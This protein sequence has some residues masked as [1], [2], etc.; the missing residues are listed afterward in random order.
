M[1]HSGDIS[2]LVIRPAL[3]YVI[4]FIRQGRVRDSQFRYPAH[5]RQLLSRPRLL[6]SDLRRIRKAV[7]GDDEFRAALSTSLDDDTDLIIQLWINQPEIGRAH[8]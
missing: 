8:V 3:E 5:L 1:A 4:E 6:K 2:D 7:E